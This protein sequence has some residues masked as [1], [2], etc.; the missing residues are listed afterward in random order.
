MNKE[1]LRKLFLEKRQTLTPKEY[2]KRNQQLL[3]HTISFIQKNRKLSH[4]H[5][6]LP[7]VKNNEPD[8]WP[9][10][11]WIINSENHLYLS[12]T[13]FKN[14]QLNHYLTTNETV[15][16]V[17]KFGIPEPVSNNEINPN[18]LDLVLVPLISYDLR[19][20]RIGY[21]AGLYD[22]FLSQTRDNCLKVGLA[23]SPPLDNIDYMDSHDI[24]LDYF[25][26]H[27]GVNSTK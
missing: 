6:F 16:E 5:L 21:G 14:R 10:F 9:I 26:S 3:Q 25:I 17:S 13:D 12:K 23:I 2:Q 19:G 27:L 22:R 1:V 4:L 20:N 7:I 11:K 24:R 15:L 18:I 8:T